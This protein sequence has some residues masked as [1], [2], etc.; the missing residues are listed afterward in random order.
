MIKNMSIK[1]RLTFTCIIIAVVAMLS[2]VVGIVISQQ[3]HS[4]YSTAI[5]NLGTSQDDIGKT[6][7]ALSKAD[8]AMSFAIASTNTDEIRDAVSSFD[9]AVDD[10]SKYSASFEGTLQSRKEQNA[11]ADFQ[12]AFEEYKDTASS[13]VNQGSNADTDSAQ[14]SS[15]LVKALQDTESLSQDAQA[16]LTSILDEKASSALALQSSAETTFRA[17]LIIA[18]LLMVIACVIVVISTISQKKTIVEPL[19]ACTARLKKL[20]QGDLRTPVPEYD[21]QNEIGEI[22]RSTQIIVDALQKII[23]DE[24]QL[25]SQ[26][27]EGD[28]TVKS[29]CKELYIA[30]FAPLLDAIR[31][32]CYRL[33]DLL[34]QID[35]ASSQV[36]AG[37]DQVSS[38]AQ[39]LSQGATEQASSVEELAATI[40]DISHHVTENAQNAGHV[41]ELA[42]Q[43][44][45]ELTESNRHMDEMTEAMAEIGNAS[46]EIGKIIKTIEDI[47]FQTNILALN[48]AVEAARAGSAGKGFAVVADE[49][50]NLA[51]KSQDAAQNTTSLIENAIA[52]VKKGTGI[53]DVT[54]QAMANVVTSSE[55]VVNLINSISD[56]SKEQAE[57]ITQVTQGVDQISSVVQTNS[58]TAQE[59]AAASEELSGQAHLLKEL[60]SAF[61]FRGRDEY[62]TGTSAPAHAASSA[63][64]L[65]LSSSDYSLD[66]GLSDEKY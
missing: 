41:Q 49:V 40:N 45:S 2:G 60:I 10:V 19:D 3:L 44:G 56:A 57:S 23:N 25:L 22:V 27:S 51:G 55:E 52:A 4:D 42:N 65:E 6:S 8:N 13:Y 16:S 29:T 64:D 47:A 58:A 5:E 38:G 12:S 54:A 21:S 46:N 37:A 9:E 50:R 24:I 20:S 30:D 33:N 63:S 28:F 34:L 61:K 66:M 17:G 7:A 18:I 35:E 53:A 14:K 11:Y 48:A 36:D 15:I 31:A 32:I 1:A 62:S 59:S 39:A 26:M 43:V